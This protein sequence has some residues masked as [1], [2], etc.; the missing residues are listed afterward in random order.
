MPATD[1]TFRLVGGQG[2]MD[3]VVASPEL[4]ANADRL[5]ERMRNYCDLKRE[6]F[7]YVMVWGSPRQSPMSLPM[8][9]AQLRAQL[10][11]LDRNRRSKHD[12]ISY[13]RD[14]NVTTQS[15]SC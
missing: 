7:C 5:A 14:G 8:T 4:A 11:Q 15:G 2:M 3:F 13:L 1:S 12:C 6:D 9:A 10:A